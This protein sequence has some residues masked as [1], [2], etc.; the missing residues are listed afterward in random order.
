M[1]L[2]LGLVGARRADFSTSV[3]NEWL[4]AQI[5]KAYGVPVADC[6]IERFEQHK[7]LVVE[8]FD[9]KLIG[10]GVHYRLRDIQRRHWV[11]LAR[12]SA[13]GGP[14]DGVIGGIVGWTDRAIDTVSAALPREFLPG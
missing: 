7:V 1:P 8:R 4:C 2:P 13:V 10:K 9:R 6:R 14:F 11:E 3:E 5:L 12:R